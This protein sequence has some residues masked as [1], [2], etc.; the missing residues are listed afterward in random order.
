MNGSFKVYV[1]C[2]TYNQS[3]YI[4]DALDGFCKQQTSFPFVCG[5]IDDASTDGEAKVI[6]D[7]LDEHFELSDSTVVKRD[8]TDDYLRIFAR[9]KDNKNCFF[10]VVF[11]KYN[12]YRKRSK[13]PYVAE[14]KEKAQYIALC[15]GD[16]FWIDPNKL[17]KQVNFMECHPEH[18]LCFCAHKELYITGRVVLNQRYDSDKD[19]CPIEDIILGGGGYMATNSM[20]F[21]RS[22]YVPYQSWAEGCPVGDLP[23]M[24]S[25]SN[26]GKVGYLSDVM[27]VHRHLSK[28]SWTS[29]MASSLKRRR[30]HNKAIIRMWKQFDR[31][32]DRRYHSL[33]LKKE[34]E[35]IT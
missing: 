9:H 7:Y 11:L 22:L 6:R 34:F 2:M 31:W 30:N 32:S 12:H 5:I 8:E 23:T 16:D 19:V 18:S 29:I 27:C 24:L 3:A 13:D 35:S 17:L 4:K 20:L 33:V 28:G 10:A 25:L 26:Q 15:E 14:W 1:S 21:R